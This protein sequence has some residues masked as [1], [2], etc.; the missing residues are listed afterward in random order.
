MKRYGVFLLIVCALCSPIFAKTTV[1]AINEFEFSK[2]SRSNMMDIAT[3]LANAIDAVRPSWQ[4]KSPEI[5]I[6]DIR[7][8][9]LAQQGGYQDKSLAI[10]RYLKAG[11]VAIG[12]I[13]RDTQGFSI[14]VSVLDVPTGSNV[15]SYETRHRDFAELRDSLP[16]IASGIV[17][18]VEGRTKRETRKKDRTKI[19][20]STGVS[21][22]QES[23][24]RTSVVP[25][26]SHFYFALSGT[27]Q[28]TLT[29]ETRY[30]AGLFPMAISSHILSATVYLHIPYSREAGLCVGVGY[31]TASAD[32]SEWT[33]MLRY[34][35]TPIYSGET[36]DFVFGLLPMSLSYDWMNDEL[37]FTF[38]LLSLSLRF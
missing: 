12:T 36:D 14:G 22:G 13:G 1:I 19:D 20:Y 38:Q 33:H 3:G 10:G 28:D 7:G 2:I 11:F 35:L 15:Y 9:N 24:T 25:G 37:L 27:L 32:F 31:S 8:A 30:S 21:V 29:L 4:I 23:V 6:R 34:T 18:A 5:V 26:G 17:K 16:G